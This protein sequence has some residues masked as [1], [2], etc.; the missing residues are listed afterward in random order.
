MQT[1]A[2]AAVVAQT[3]DSAE[4]IK[5]APLI[6]QFPALGRPIG[7]RLVEALAEKS[8]GAT[9]EDMISVTITVPQ[10]QQALAPAVMALGTDKLAEAM[11]RAKDTNVARQATAYLATMAGK[12]RDGVAKAVIAKYKFNP[13]AKDVPW[14]TALYVPGIQWGQD[15]GRNLVS[16]L[17]S[18]YLWCDLNDKKQQIQQIHNNVAGVGIDQQVGYSSQALFANPTTEGYLTEWGKL[19]GRKELRRMLEEQGVA[20][21]DRFK[22]I[23]D[24]APEKSDKS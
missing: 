15:H 21:K 7:M 18:W 3:K 4:L 17:I 20:D 23:I 5:L 19:V 9:A 16:N 24:A 2:A 12:D 14:N 10:L 1:W 6:N 22:R 8:G 11:A 13:K